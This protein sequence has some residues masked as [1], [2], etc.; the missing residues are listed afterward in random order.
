MTMQTNN[1]QDLSGKIRLIVTDVD[2]TLVD[3]NRQCPKINI[4][5]FRKA[6]KQGIQVVVATGRPLEGILPDIRSWGLDGVIQYVVANNGADIYH[7]EDDTTTHLHFIPSR[8]ANVLFQRYANWD[9][10]ICIYEGLTLLTNKVNDDYIKRSTYARLDMKTVDLDQYLKE[11]MPKLLMIAPKDTLDA[12]ESDYQN[13]PIDPIKLVHCEHNLIEVLHK[14]LSKVSG[15][16]LIASYY[17]INHDQIMAFGDST[18]DLEMITTYQ[19]VAV[20]NA[21]P[22]ILETAKYHALSNDQG[23]VGQFI[24]DYVLPKE[25]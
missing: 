10:A 6:H 14:D 1:K 21:N 20:S 12:I 23:G 19:G 16:D 11:D 8:E 17:G 7:V 5:A 3:S 22:K 18:N 25:A 13:H 15:V 9:V 24:I 4:E 2:G